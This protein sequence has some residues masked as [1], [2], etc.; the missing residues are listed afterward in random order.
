VVSVLTNNPS[1]KVIERASKFDIP[2]QIFSKQE[3]NEGFLL[4]NI[5]LLEPDLIVLAGFY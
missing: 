4:Q 1:A 5:N 3:L 2:T